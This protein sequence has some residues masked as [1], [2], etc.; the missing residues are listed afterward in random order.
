[1]QTAAAGGPDSAANTSA[2]PGIQKVGT[3]DKDAREFPSIV[4]N[5]YVIVGSPD[6]VA[7]QLREVVKDLRFGHLMLLLQFGN[8]SKQLAS[9]NTR[10]YAEQVMPRLA[11]LWSEWKDHWWP[12]PLPS[13]HRSRPDRP[14]AALAAE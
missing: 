6:Q 1:M 8:M 7:E 4:E 11:D 5:G 14:I 12:T 10:H 2:R 13:A 3:I 9:Y